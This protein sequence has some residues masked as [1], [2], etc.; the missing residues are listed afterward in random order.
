[1]HAAAKVN[2]F[3]EIQPGNLQNMTD[4]YLL[5]IGLAANAQIQNGAWLGTGDGTKKNSSSGMEC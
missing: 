1:V 3:I 2:S 4:E 5:G